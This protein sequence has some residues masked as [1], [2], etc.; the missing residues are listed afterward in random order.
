MAGS[1]GGRL[2]LTARVVV[3]ATLME[4]CAALLE[5]GQA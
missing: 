3:C 2:I 1:Y 4:G 5:L